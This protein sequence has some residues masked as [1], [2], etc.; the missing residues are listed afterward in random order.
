MHNPPLVNDTNAYRMTRRGQLSFLNHWSMTRKTEFKLF[1]ASDTCTIIFP[2]R[3][4]LTT[5]QW[6]ECTELSVNQTQHI[7]VI[8]HHWSTS[9]QWHKCRLLSLNHTQHIRVIDQWSMTRTLLVNYTN[10]CTSVIDRWSMTRMNVIDHSQWHEGMHRCHWPWS[11][12]LM[13]AS[14]SLTTGQW[15]KCVIDHWSMT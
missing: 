11:I 9:G 10:V 6:H 13:H 5:G 2:Y 3:V 8:D 1:L 4:S 7:Y 15:H 14:V 12:T